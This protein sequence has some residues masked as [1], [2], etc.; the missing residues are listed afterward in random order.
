V[1]TPGGLP[2]RIDPNS[3][4]LIESM[5]VQFLVPAP[6][7]GRFPLLMWDGGGL[8][9]VSWETTPDG[10]EGFQHWFLRRGSPVYVSD[11][12]DRSRSDFPLPQLIQGDLSFLVAKG[13]S[14]SGS[15]PGPA[16][17]TATRR[18]AGCSPAASC[19]TIPH[20]NLHELHGPNRA[21]LYDDGLRDQRRPRRA[22][23]PRRGGGGN[24]A[25]PGGAV[26]LPRRAEP[27]R[28]GEGACPAR[29]GGGWRTRGRS[30][31]CAARSTVLDHAL[32]SVGDP[33]TI[34]A[35]RGLPVLVVYSDFI[36]QDA[37]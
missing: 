34:E 36:D 26:R 33:G 24:G 20:H 35:L 15:A 2:A 6:Q 5:Y 23:R 22:D 32:R 17:V 14:A 30:R 27:T 28:Q 9:G 21:A 4:Y 10:H 1:F 16:H 12:V 19:R 8:T 7:R 25:Q 31:R 11:A 13:S 29:A 18:N 3:Q 37:R